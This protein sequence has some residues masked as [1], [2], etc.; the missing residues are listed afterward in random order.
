MDDGT[1]FSIYAKKN[2]LIL[3]FIKMNVYLCRKYSWWI[4]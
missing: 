3:W 1:Y 4:M 2:H